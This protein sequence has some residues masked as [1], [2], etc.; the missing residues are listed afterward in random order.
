M[1]D[2]QQLLVTEDHDEPSNKGGNGSGKRRKSNAGV[3]ARSTDLDYPGLVPVKTFRLAVSG[4][5]LITEVERRIIDTEDFQRLR[6][7]RQLGTVNMVYPTALHTRFD[8]CIGTMAMAWRMVKAIEDNAHNVVNDQVDERSISAQQKILVRLYALLHDIPHIPFGHTLE[9]ELMIFERHDENPRRLKRFLGK[10][11]AIGRIIREGFNYEGYGNWGEEIYARLWS[12]YNWHGDKKKPPGNQPEPIT[13][14]EKNADEPYGPTELVNPD[15]AFVYDLVS[16]T[17]CADLLDYLARDSYFCNLGSPLEYRFLNFLYL[18]EVD[19]ER[20]EAVKYRRVVVRLWKPKHPEPRRDT[21]TDLA[22]LMEARYM[23]AERAYFHHAK[24]I[25][26]SM[27]GRALHDEKLVNG[28]SEDMMYNHSDDSLLYELSNS[29]SPVAKRIAQ[30]LLGRQLYKNRNVEFELK[31]NRAD[32]DSVQAHDHKTNKVD[33]ILRRISD[34]SQRTA[35]ENDFANEIEAEP[36]DVII[37]APPEAMNM[38]AAMM[39][40]LWKGRIIPFRDVDDPVI[41]PRLDEILHAHRLLWSVWVFFHPRLDAEQVA[42]LKEKCDIEFLSSSNSDARMEKVV[43]LRER[44][45]ERYLRDK[46]SDI[47]CTAEE[48]TRLRR[49]AAVTLSAA[50]LDSG[51]SFVFQKQL[52]NVCTEVFPRK[53]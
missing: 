34:P 28:L 47:P 46:K 39:K 15:D 13:P 30:M 12:I 19:S 9:D 32:F 18:Q 11:S 42:L 4:D 43:R 49:E 41:G 35:L 40:V 27:L 14:D 36:G 48:Y 50:A 37:Y 51:R 52:H 45:I 29:K 31:Y 7:V 1:P 21:L 6:R 22:R 8:H 23:V 16:N 5:V 20:A 3:K 25:S 2:E 24:I 53:K 17:V 26:G 44:Q 38:K 33:E 10:D